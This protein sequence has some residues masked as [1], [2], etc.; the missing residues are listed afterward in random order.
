MQEAVRTRGIIGIAAIV[1]SLGLAA[2][3]FAADIATGKDHPAVGRYEGSEI[4]QYDAKG[5]E[6]VKLPNAPAPNNAKTVDP[7][8]WLLP[9][10]GKLTRIR[11]EGPGERSALEI[12]R[13]FEGALKQSGFDILFFCKRDECGARST[14]WDIARGGLSVASNW[15]THVYLLARKDAPEG[16]ITVGILAVELAGTTN[17]PLMPQLAVTVVEGKPMETGKISLVQ[18]DALQKAIDAEGKVALYGIYFDVDKAEVKSDSAPQLAEIAKYLQAAPKARVLV[19][20]HTDNSGAIDY[21]RDLSDRRAASVVAALAGQH[22]VAN[23]RMFP[24]GVGLAAPIA[25]NLTE[26]GKAKNRRVEIVALPS[27]Q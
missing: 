8:L 26:D 5:Y 15:D 16:V 14:F 23:E 2:P 17:R 27:A 21:N 25:S 11:Y 7:N 22:G 10:E 24:V 9:L 20:G 1:F 6:E 18:A 4:K 12:V 19:V 3:A 13:N